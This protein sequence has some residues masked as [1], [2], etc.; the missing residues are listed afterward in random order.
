MIFMQDG[1]R[2][3]TAAATSEWLRE[4]EI[5]LLGKEVWP[6]NSPDLNPIENVWAILEDLM[7]SD[8]GEPRTLAQLEKSLVES[9]NKIKLETLENLYLSMPSRILDVIRCKGGY[10]T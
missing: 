5:Q 10:P 8:K 9:W 4:S 6:P 3:H 2:A 7:I 1:A